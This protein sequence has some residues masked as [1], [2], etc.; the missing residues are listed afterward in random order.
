MILPGHLASVVLERRHLR[1]E[2]YPAL[3][4]TL[5]P[6]VI[7][8]LLFYVLRV[9]SHSRIPM[10]TLVG[11]LGT[12]LVATLL[13]LA[14]G[15]R[16]RWG[17]AWW[18]GYGGHLLCDSPLAGGDLAFLFPF[19]SYSFESHWQPFSYLWGLQEW[20]WHMMIA[21]TLLVGVTLYLEWRRHGLRLRRSTLCGWWRALVTLTAPDDFSRP[22][23]ESVA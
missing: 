7:D 22:S 20:P 5:A 19:I 12:T 8:K 2:L 16:W 14:L 13:G 11:W 21:E 23:K 15:R 6:D 9:S 10:H 1:V 18:V 4:A 17:W 3:A